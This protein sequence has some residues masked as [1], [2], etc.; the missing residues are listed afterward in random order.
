MYETIS[1]FSSKPVCMNCIGILV[2]GKT[3]FQK[4]IF[5]QGLSCMGELKKSSIPKMRINKQEI[6]MKKKAIVAFITLF[7]LSLVFSNTVF[8]QQQQKKVKYVVAFQIINPDTFEVIQSGSLEV[9]S[10]S[11]RPQ[12]DGWVKSQ[13]RQQLGWTGSDI[14]TKNGVRQKLVF[15]SINEIKLD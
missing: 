7:V 9:K 12:Q 15:V 10:P 11:G 2:G 5:L 13:I 8:A 3:E 1:D 14:R 4:D 6:F